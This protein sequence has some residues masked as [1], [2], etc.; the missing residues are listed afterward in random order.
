MIAFCIKTFERPKMVERLVESIKQ[1]YPK[2]KIYI[3][4]DSREPMKGSFPMEFDSGLSAGRNLLIRKTKEP[5]LLFLDDDFVF[6][7]QTRIENLVKILENNPDLGII[8]G[9][10]KQDGTIRHYEGYVRFQGDKLVYDKRVVQR[11]GFI[12][13]GLILN[14]FLA[15]REVFDNVRWDND[16]KLA[17]HSDFFLRLGYTKWKVGYFDGVIIEHKPMKA[18]EYGKFRARGKFFTKLMMEKRGIKQIINYEGKI[19]K[20]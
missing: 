5:Y 16:L 7:E 1:F 15:R 9:A 4:D 14:F 10:M 13:T 3:A 12:E 11:D 19:F 18:G 8:G 6:T 2:A 20:L 17:E